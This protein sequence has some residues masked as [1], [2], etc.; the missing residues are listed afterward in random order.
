MVLH[1]RKMYEGYLEEGPS[2]LSFQAE[3]KGLSKVLSV[4]KLCN[5]VKIPVLP[6]AFLNTVLFDKKVPITSREALK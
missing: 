3:S 5:S 6:V 2:F 1:V 4:N